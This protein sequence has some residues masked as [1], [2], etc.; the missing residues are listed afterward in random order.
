MHLGKFRESSQVLHYIFIYL[1]IYLYKL[2][3]SQLY[4][5]AISIVFTSS[6]YT[7]HA[8]TRNFH[9]KLNLKG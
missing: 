4:I 2:G 3:H 5:V 1:I 8:P 7:K 9:F 6:S